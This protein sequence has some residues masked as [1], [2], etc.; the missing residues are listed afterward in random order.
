MI[1]S[2]YC[3]Y[4]PVVVR[5]GNGESFFAKWFDA[6]PANQVIHEDQF[7]GPSGH[8]LEPDNFPTEESL[9][10]YL[11][12]NSGLLME[13]GSDFELSLDL[14]ESDSETSDEDL[15][16]ESDEEQENWPPPALPVLPWKEQ[17]SDWSQMP[18]LLPKLS[19]DQELSLAE[20]M[21]VEH[22][23]SI[24]TMTQQ[25]SSTDFCFVP[26]HL[27]QNENWSESLVDVEDLPQSS[28][29]PSY[30]VPVYQPVY[31]YHPYQVLQPVQPVHP[32]SVIGWVNIQPLFI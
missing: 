28:I 16:L 13:K 19:M 32:F 25:Q 5:R 3:N 7:F 27:P 2:D 8:A 1:E 11:T 29:V 23:L 4:S 24:P 14:D 20:S 18:P 17:T 9:A 31:P 22:R 26:A 15:P 21:D 6:I 12:T 10:K 30:G